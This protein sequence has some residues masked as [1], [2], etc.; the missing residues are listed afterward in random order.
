MESIKI[1]C[2]KIDVEYENEQNEKVMPVKI[3]I[4]KV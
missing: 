4:P 1:K 3:K 2:R